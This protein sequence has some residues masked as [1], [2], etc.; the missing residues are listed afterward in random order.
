MPTAEITRQS[1]AKR[2]IVL[3]EGSLEGVEWSSS[4]ETLATVDE[5]G[6]VTILEGNN[7]GNQIRRREGADDVTTVIINAVSTTNPDAAAEVE[8]KILKTVTGVA[9]LN[10]G[11]AIQAVK[12]YNA[13]GIESNMP[14]DGLNIVVSTYTDGTRSIVKIVK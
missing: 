1:D 7:N 8:I 5:N 6:L 11:K 14:F 10:A 9:D 4:D 13:A 3:P 12:Y 2:S